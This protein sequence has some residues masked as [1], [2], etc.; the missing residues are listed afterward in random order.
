[1]SCHS[2][3]Y[4]SVSSFLFFFFVL[5]TDD[6][7]IIDIYSAGRAREDHF[8]SRFQLIVL[9]MQKESSSP[10]INLTA[11]VPKVGVAVFLLKGKKLLLGRRLSAIGNR[12]FALPGGHLEFGRLTLSLYPLF[13]LLQFP[14]S[15]F[16]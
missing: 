6:G 14:V 11:P 4:D 5:E 9:E 16:F 8:S 12:T 2:T 3:L 15:G 13:L 1:M 7:K 10:S